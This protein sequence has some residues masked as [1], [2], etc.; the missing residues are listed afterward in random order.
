VSGSLN[1][2]EK[3]ITKSGS[4]SVAITSFIGLVA[5]GQSGTGVIFMVT[6]TVFPGMLPSVAL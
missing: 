4:S 2:F 3:S 6:E 5:V 1:T